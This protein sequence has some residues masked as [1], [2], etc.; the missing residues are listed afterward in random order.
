MPILIA[1]VG[2]IATAYF[3]YMRARNAAQ[4]TSELVDVANDVRLAARRFGFRR[5]RDV[6]PGD[7]IED[8]NLAMGTIALAF[9]NLTGLPT[10]QDRDRLKLALRKTL[11]LSEDEAEETLILG[12]WIMGQCN[13]PS[14]AIE[15]VSRRLFKMNGLDNWQE[16]LTILKGS[17]ANGTQMTAQQAEALQDIQ[18]T[19]RVR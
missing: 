3:L 13:G 12:T 8:A 11:N 4:M 6:H 16:L 18:T 17:I 1:L 19:F 10:Q 2:A 5:Q 7:S 15:R 14:P 9:S